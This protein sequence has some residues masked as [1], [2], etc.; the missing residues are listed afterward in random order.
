MDDNKQP[1]PASPEGTIVENAL[2]PV[3][4]DEAAALDAALDEALLESFPASDPIAPFRK[5]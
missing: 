3:N 2:A 1:R 5:A 4:S